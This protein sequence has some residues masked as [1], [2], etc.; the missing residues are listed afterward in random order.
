MNGRQLVHAAAVGHQGSG[1]LMPGRGGSGKSSTS[2]ACL[3]AGMDFLGDDYLAVALDPEPRAYRLY[4]TA[5][6][7]RENLNSYPELR[8]RCRM[9]LRESF[10][11]AVLYLDDAYA[12]QL[13]ESLPL[14]LVLRPSIAAQAETTLAGIEAREIESAF[15]VETL[16]HLPHA[17]A[18]TV[19]FLDRVAREI[20]RAAILLGS[21]RARIPIAIKE[22]FSKLPAN[23]GR[24]EIADSRPAISV[25]VHFSEEDREELGALA[26][27]IQAQDYP[28]AELTSR[29]PSAR[30]LA[31]MVAAKLPGNVKCF[32]FDDPIV[33]AEAWNRAI[34][35]S[36][37]ERLLV[38]EPGD[39]LEPGALQ[40][41]GDALA[42]SEAAYV[43]PQVSSPFS[44]CAE[45]CYSRVRSAS[46]DYFSSILSI[47]VANIRSGSNVWS[48]GDCTDR[49]S[50][51][52][53][54]GRHALPNRSAFLTRWTGNPSASSGSA[55]GK[56]RNDACLARCAGTAA[57]GCRKCMAKMACV[58]QSGSHRSGELQPPAHLS[59]AFARVDQGRSAA[60]DAVGICRRAWSKIRFGGKRWP[61]DRHPE[62]SNRP[63]AETGPVMW[64]KLYWPEGAIRPIGR[65]GSLDRA[66]ECARRPRGADPRRLERSRRPAAGTRKRFLLRY[67]VAMRAP[68]GSEIRVDWRSLPHTD[69]ALRHPPVPLL[70]PIPAEHSLVAALGGNMEDRLGWKCDALFLCRQ[71]GLNWNLI[72]ELLRWRSKARNR[73]EQL[74]RERLLEIAAV[75]TRPPRTAGLERIL[76]SVLR[77]YRERCAGS[78]IRRKIDAPRANLLVACRREFVSACGAA[79]RGCAMASAIA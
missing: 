39:R 69:F 74:Q 71:P 68:D 7:D 1:I 66:R 11:K 76:A 45:C 58:G 38:I 18:H 46:A 78:A 55:A 51:T 62:R 33:K 31:G 14:K 77:T 35:E 24:H 15:S 30:E 65:C 44:P 26:A 36:F 20:P 32:S 27:M 52:S 63:R 60:G 75:V 2:L 70:E 54:C 48:E 5:K 9:V 22:S 23:S 53:R 49:G 10:S 17:D 41:L 4:S 72:A 40:T 28:R 13:Q 12:S 79:T 47:K 67:R 6:L 34:R 64:G 42:A 19:E 29:E 50:Q 25:L 3:L 59:R 37:A 16:L 43:I 8:S 56:L 21:D 73:L 61:I 57:S